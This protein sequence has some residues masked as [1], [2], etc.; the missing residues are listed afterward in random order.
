MKKVCI[1]TGSR[2]EYGLLRHLMFAMQRSSLLHMEV[3]VTGAHL[4]TK[5]GLTYR[6]IEADGFHIDYK[7]EIPMDL[8][9]PVAIAEALGQVVI[10]MSRTLASMRPDLIVVLGDRSEIFAA[11]SAA[12]ILGIPIAHI[13]G[14][15]HGEGTIDNVMRHCI[16]KMAQ[17]HFVT[18]ERARRTVLQLGED[19]SRVFDVGALA[20]DAI[21]GIELISR[22]ELANKLH[23]DA[24]KFWLLMTYHPL[25]FAGHNSLHELDSILGAIMS[26]GDNYEVVITAPNA[27]AGN[28]QVR[29]RL[30]EFVGGQSNVRLV[31]NL[32]PY[33]L[34]V[35]A[36]SALVV[37]NSSSGIYEAPLLETPTVNVG[38]RQKGRSCGDSVISVDSERESILMAMT[39]VIEVGV[40]FG[41]YPYGHEFAA[42]K[43]VKKI[44]EMG[45]L[46]AEKGF[47]DVNF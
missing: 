22:Q 34:S 24:K 30:N 6:E 27:D 23:L 11:S 20:T 45:D 18:H 5:Y 47:I 26:L 39:H 35:L 12:M 10:E 28:S 37:G 32:G 8:D 46:N 43:I 16:T 21:L 44:E 38:P 13:G 36:E 4:S 3:L 25:T 17:L 31:E 2:A 42:P 19:P 1:V 9:T 40:S 7:V 41:N 33:Y 29:D 15:D 14:G